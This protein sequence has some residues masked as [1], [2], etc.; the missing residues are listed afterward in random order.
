M[1]S[2]TKGARSEGAVLGA[3]LKAGYAVLIPF[4]TLRYDLA[5]EI[6]SKG[7]KTIPPHVPY[8]SPSRPIGWFWF[9]LGRPEKFRT[10]QELSAVS[11]SEYKE[12]KGRRAS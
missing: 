12:G 9:R 5:V 6:P 11:C 2:N 4:G 7:I 3:L 8:S 1:N 10:R